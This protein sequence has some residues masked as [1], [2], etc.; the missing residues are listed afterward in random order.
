[1]SKR[2]VGP[3]L[4]LALAGLIASVLAASAETGTL[5]KADQ[6]RAEP[7]RDATV[8]STL[9]AGDRVEILLRQGA[10]YRV[11]TAK[12]SGWLHMLSVRRGEA[13][14]AGAAS[15]ASG[16]LALA[17]GRA[18]TGKVVA[19]TGI[20]GLDEEQLKSATYSESELGYSDSLVASSA[21]AAKFAAGGKLVARASAYLPAPQ[22]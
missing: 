15:E 19:T 13:A 3:T 10:W 5:L 9:A 6:L 16:L 14:K 21:A 11:K 4:V 1:M 20:R 22:Q 7:F 12:A 8:V 17:S 2:I 18:G